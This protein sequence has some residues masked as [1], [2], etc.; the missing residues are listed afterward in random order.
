MG[1]TG[2]A[3]PVLLAH[4]D[5]HLWDRLLIHRG[6]TALHTAEQPGGG[7]YTVQAAIAAC[8]AQARSVDSTDW[9]R[10]AALYTVLAYLA[11]LPVVAL[12]RAVAVGMADGPARG[13]ELADELRDERALAGYPAL[14][15]VRASLLQRLGRH[16]E[17][18][19]EFQRA[20]ERTSNNQQ[21]RLYLHQASQAQPDEQ[22]A[23]Q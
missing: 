20:A 6:L 21:R 4:Q 3:D 17:A 14:S 10:I 22:E 18:Q 16:H 1:G 12:N 2:G 11:P 5:R 13:L 7:P 19:A 8:H 23:G 15:A 9:P